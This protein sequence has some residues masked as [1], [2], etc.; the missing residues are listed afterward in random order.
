[1]QLQAS[2]IRASLLA[3][4][5]FG[6]DTTQTETTAPPPAL[7]IAHP[8]VVEA[9]CGE[10]QLGMAGDDCDLAVRIDGQCYFVSGT[11][12]DEHGDA[13]A[14]DGFCNAI[15]HARVTGHTE[16]RTFVAESFELLPAGG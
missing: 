4:L 5:A 11:S 6:C 14:A 10:C 1:V 15:R 7:V 3:I 9:S 16:G 8:T 13:H 2:L 12:M